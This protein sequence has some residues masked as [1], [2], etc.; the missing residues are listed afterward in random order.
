MLCIRKMNLMDLT[1]QPCFCCVFKCNLNVA[2]FFAN[3]HAEHCNSVLCFHFI[4][5]KLL[6]EL[7]ILKL[8][9]Y[10]GLLNKIKTAEGEKKL[11]LQVISLPNGLITCHNLN[12]GEHYDVFM[13]S[14]DTCCLR[15]SL[16]N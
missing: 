16:C 5:Q 15:C 9:T 10:S 7:H 13:F 4:P 1:T 6:R 12:K 2:F 14:K 3:K 11:V 8:N